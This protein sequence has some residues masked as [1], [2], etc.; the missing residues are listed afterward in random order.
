MDSSDAI[1]GE[2]FS[3]LVGCHELSSGGGF[4]VIVKGSSFSAIHFFFFEM[5]ICIDQKLY[6]IKELYWEAIEKDP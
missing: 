6:S 5:V 1:G 3:L 4:N 2:G